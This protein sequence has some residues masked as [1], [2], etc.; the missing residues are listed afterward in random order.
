M[1]YFTSAGNNGTLAYNNNA[2]NFATASSTAPNAGEQ[3]LNFAPS[4]AT[5]SVN[6]PV[7]IPP[8]VPGEFVVLLV[9]WDQPYVTGAKN[10]GGA[11]S[12]IDVCITGATGNGQ[13]RQWQ[14]GGHYLQRR[15]CTGRRSVSDHDHR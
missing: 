9:E 7:T 10:S 4:G 1:A 14:F 15:Q 12:S 2:P 6:L 13:S 3:L 5:A 11:T 8:L